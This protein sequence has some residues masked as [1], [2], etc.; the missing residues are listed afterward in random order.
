MTLPQ[1]YRAVILNG[2]GMKNVT[3]GKKT[4]DATLS[5]G[6]ILV[7]VTVRPINPSD[8][9]SILGVYPGFQPP[10]AFKDSTPGLEG[11]GVVAAIGE[12]V[13]HVKVGQR[14]VPIFA[15][16]IS[17]N[18]SFQ[19]YVKV[20]NVVPIPDDVSDESAAQLIVNP[21]TVVGM[22]EYLHVPKGEWVV[23]TASNSVLGRQM[24]QVCKHRGIK[25]VNLIRREEQKAELMSLGADAVVVTADL[26]PGAVAA[27][28]LAATG[29]SRPFGAVDAVGG[30]TTLALSDAVRDKGV[31]LV[32]GLQ[33]G[34]VFQASGPA[35]LFRGVT[36][37][38]YW[39]ATH[40]MA[41]KEDV[42]AKFM[43][44]M[45]PLSGE[46]FD[47]ADVMAA[48]K[49][50]QLPGRGGKVAV[51]LVNTC[52]FLNPFS[53][54]LASREGHGFLQT[55]NVDNNDDDL[56]PSSNW[57]IPIFRLGVLNVDSNFEQLWDDDT[58]FK[59]RL[60]N[61]RT[62]SDAALLAS[63]Y[64][65][66]IRHTAIPSI[67]HQMWKGNCF[68]SDSLLQH[69]SISSWRDSNPQATHI[70]WTD[71]AMDEFVKSYYPQLLKRYRA[72]PR[73]VFRTDLGRL[74]ILQTF[75]GIYADADTTIIKPLNEWV[76]EGTTGLD[77]KNTSTNG[78]PTLPDSPFNM[79][80]SLETDASKAIIASAP[81]HAV[82]GTTIN[83]ILA[84]LQK[85]RSWSDDAADPVT[86]TGPEVFS[87]GIR[88]YLSGAVDVKWADLH[89][90]FFNQSRRLA[91][92]LVFPTGVFGIPTKDLGGDAQEAAAVIGADYE[93]VQREKLVEHHFSHTWI[94]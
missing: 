39:L 1:D 49:A 23:Q 36:V 84:R 69:A 38:G 16:A 21:M 37:T 5:P 43:G 45:V 24:I 71:E 47:L 4:L 44:I 41:M 31:I 76:V 17:G 65:E 35:C 22:L 52:V 90:Q 88:S 56:V 18:G 58:E 13:S 83:L 19:E 12:G 15:E 27:A 61:P 6:Q 7:K 34:V 94:N 51:L 30:N 72:F 57:T 9:F 28:I 60:Q 14:V 89:G 40:I 81:Y 10:N 82:L 50:S 93:Y 91:D 64:G 87:Y 54:L 29:G 92:V 26:E 8:V 42:V 67:I 59:T 33:G 32:Y 55:S 73:V 80:V 86:L 75:G 74:L 68:D 78:I 3:I 77:F 66:K 48:I 2:T 85:L 63:L 20:T 53:D 46:K 25:T 11:C 79:M 62:Q 70:L